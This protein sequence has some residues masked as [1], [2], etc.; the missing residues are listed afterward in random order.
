MFLAQGGELTFLGITAI[1]V[2]VAGVI[3]ILNS[4]GFTEW[5]RKN[6]EKRDKKYRDKK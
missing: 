1:L 4:F 6:K 2:Y 3:W 5:Q